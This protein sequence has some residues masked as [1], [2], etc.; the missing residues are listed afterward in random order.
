MG[1]R[2]N[3]RRWSSFREMTMLHLSEL[4]EKRDERPG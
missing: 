3:L 1:Q 2:G 4:C